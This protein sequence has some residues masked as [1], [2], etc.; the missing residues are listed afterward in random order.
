MERSRQLQHLEQAERHVLRGEQNVSD[1]EQRIEDLENH[2]Y[3]VTLARELLETFLRTQA[4]F[5][6]H[7]DLILRELDHA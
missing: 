5:V 7:R 4:Q 3:D 2:G 6:T 1:R